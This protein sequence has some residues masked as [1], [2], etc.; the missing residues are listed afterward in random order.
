[1]LLCARVAKDHLLPCLIVDAM[2]FRCAFGLH[3]LVF[4]GAV[5]GPLA[6]DD[7]RKTRCKASVVDATQSLNDP[8]CVG[9][10]QLTGCGHPVCAQCVQHRAATACF[11]SSTQATV[12]RDAAG[13]QPNAA[14]GPFAA[15]AAMSLCN[16]VAKA[17]DDATPGGPRCCGL[18]RSGPAGAPALPSL[19]AAL[20]S[21]KDADV[22]ANHAEHRMQS[23]L[24]ML[25][26]SLT[27]TTAARSPSD[28]AS[29]TAALRTIVDPAMAAFVGYG[30][31][32]T[33]CAAG[34]AVE[35]DDGF[36]G[37][38]DV[39]SPP[40]SNG[41]EPEA[42]TLDEVVA[43]AAAASPFFTFVYGQV[44][45]IC[46]QNPSRS[47][48]KQCRFTI[49]PGCQQEY[50]SRGKFLLHDIVDSSSADGRE[51]LPQRTGDARE[52]CDGAPAVVRVAPVERLYC[53]DCDAA[54]RRIDGQPS[55]P[56]HSGSTGGEGSRHVGHTV[57]TFRDLNRDLVASRYEVARLVSAS[58]EAMVRAR[59]QSDVSLRDINGTVSVAQQFC[60]E[61]RRLLSVWEAS[62][63][64]AANSARLKLNEYRA[65]EEMTLKVWQDDLRA[66]V[67]SVDEALHAMT[68]S[69][70]AAAS[71]R[72]VPAPTSL[73][74]VDAAEMPL[75]DQCAALLA[76]SAVATCS[77]ADGRAPPAVRPA[78]A[79]IQGWCGAS[80]FV[81]SRFRWSSRATSGAARDSKGSADPVSVPRIVADHQA[82]ASTACA[83]GFGRRRG[84]GRLAISTVVPERVILRIREFRGRAAHSCV[85]GF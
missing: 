25:K 18:C 82:A 17:L 70:V 66:N 22:S 78:T 50:H 27:A 34:G 33:A 67:E 37:N 4:P 62:V 10:F 80:S 56:R 76:T 6:A 63:E 51:Y 20:P 83:N 41:N 55:D 74:G 85:K 68:L 30:R 75:T 54:F 60:A 48:C 71:P 29:M 11:I 9:V 49:C 84:R 8:L 5:V 46:E 2:S 52:G 19:I 32:S 1:M 16:M 65:A 39:E 53:R 15:E 72:T 45:G 81:E 14:R 28:V 31:R 64:E 79:G 35:Q 24:R 26:Q 42:E 77:A 12:L 23:A 38:A 21:S 44:C 40:A 47:Y 59:E 7:Q 13:D 36:D 69:T 73:E 43:P 57:V 61:Y 58:R 3:P